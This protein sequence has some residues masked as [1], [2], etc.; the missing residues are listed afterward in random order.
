MHSYVE[1]SFP[2]LMVTF[3]LGIERDKEIT[4]NPS[5]KPCSYEELR[6]TDVQTFVY[7]CSI[8]I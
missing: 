4:L 8:T 3:S 7:T 6:C 2:G 1:S 5:Y